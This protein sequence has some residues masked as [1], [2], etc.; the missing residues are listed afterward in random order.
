MKQTQKT[1]LR[2]WV[3]LLTV[4]GLISLAV[5]PI[6]LSAQ[7]VNGYYST[8]AWTATTIAGQSTFT[9][10]PDAAIQV[11]NYP[12]NAVPC[13]NLATLYLG[14][15]LASG[16]GP[17]PL[18]AD[19][20]GNFGFWA[21]VGTYQYTLTTTSGQS[22]GP[23]PV[24]LGGGS[25][26]GGGGSPGGSSGAIQYNL[27]GTSFGGVNISGVIKGN[28]TLAPSA[29]IP[30]VDFL[31]PNGSGAGLSGV[32]LL[33]Q[34]NSFSQTQTAPNFTA[35]QSMLT[36]ALTDSGL[37]S[38]NCVQAGSGGLLTTS[39][40]PCGS[41]GGGGIPYPSAGVPQSTGSAWGSSL[42]LGTAANNIVQVNS[43]G[44]LPALNSPLLF[45]LTAANLSG[46]APITIAG[47][48]TLSF[49]ASPTFS[50]IVR[51]SYIGLT[52]NITSFTLAAAADGQEKTLTF[53]QLSSG[54]FT[55]TPPSNVLGFLAVGPTA[56]TCS[57]Q[58]YSYSATQTAW[59]ADSL[60]ITSASN[61]TPPI[62]TV[63]AGT[64][65][66]TSPTV[67]VSAGSNND[68]GYI[69]LTTGST[70]SPSAAIATVSF[71][72]PFP[73]SPRCYSWPATA[74]TQALVG[75]AA[76]QVF[77]AN[78]STS[79]FQITQ[80]STGLTASTAYEWGYKCSVLGIPLYAGANNF[81]LGSGIP[82]VVGG[83]AWGT[84]IAAPSGTVVG[85]TDTQTLT[86]KTLASPTITGTVAIPTGSTAVTQTTGDN[87][88]KLATDAFVL[89]NGG[90]GSAVFPSTPGVVYNTTTS[91]ARNATPSDFLTL[92]GYYT[93]AYSSGTTYK[94]NDVAV[95]GSGNNYV[96]LSA[97]NVGNALTNTTFWHFLGGVSST[98][99]G[100]NCVTAG[101]VQIGISTAGVPNCAAVSYLNG[102]AI[103]VSQG[104]IGINSSGQLITPSLAS[105]TL[106]GYLTDE[107]GT[108]TVVFNISPGLAGTP[109]APT[110]T[111]GTNTTQLA[112]TAFVLAN[113]GGTFTGAIQGS[114]PSPTIT[115]FPLGFYPQYTAFGDSIT[116]GFD[117]SS[118]TAAYPYVL[119]QAIGA[120]PVDYGN[121]GG[122]SHQQD[123]NIFNN[124]I[125]WAPQTVVS[126]TIG[127]NNVAQGGANTNQESMYGLNIEAQYAWFALTPA[128]K[129]L[130]N[131]GSVTY[132]GTWAHSTLFG[133]N[134]PGKNCT[135][136]TSC[137]ATF[138]GTGSILY[139]ITGAQN[140]NA[141]TATL[142]CDGT[143]TGATL[144]FAGQGGQTFVG[145]PESTQFT[146]VALSAGAH[147]CIVQST[148]STGVLD[149]E[150]A[151]FLPGTNITDG[152]LVLA[153]EIPDLNPVGTTT[154]AYQAFN[155]S[156]TTQLIGDG[157]VN[158]GYVVTHGVL[159]ANNYSD[160]V[161]HPNEYGQWLLS[162]PFVSELATISSKT[163]T[164]PI[165]FATRVDNIARSGSGNI[166][167]ME[168]EGNGSAIS[169]GSL[170]VTLG[171]GAG[172]DLTTSTEVTAIGQSACG[173]D[174][175]GS[176]NT[177]IGGTAL[178][179]VTTG[180]LNTGIGAAALDDLIGGSDNTAVGASALNGQTAGNYNSAVGYV[181]CEFQTTGGTD[182]CMGAWTGTTLATGGVNVTTD[183][184][185][186]LLGYGASKNTASIIT[187]STAIGANA[188]ASASHQVSLG[189]TTVTSE[190]FGGVTVYPEVR[191][192]LTMTAGTSD[193]AT[194]TG[195]TASSNCLFSPTNA[196]AAT[197]I[198]TTYISS[199]TTN[200]VTIT[201]VTGASTGTLNI[202]CTIN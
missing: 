176:Y 155:A 99:T 196:T 184:T 107:T 182:T 39:G 77:P 119:G 95:D 120:Y 164:Q 68:T 139:L 112:T 169:T 84:T 72:N 86:N 16:T 134:S 121:V 170:N 143:A 45:N 67:S 151:A 58:H 57:S 62:P 200:S 49:T 59:I 89:A 3:A 15:S 33:A 189:S 78:T 20:Y 79:S 175:T 93:G 97:G 159:G 80:G 34:A 188:L 1:K 128:R 198:A 172:I 35:S 133:A 181:A 10:I 37:T 113:S 202:H 118:V 106:A 124:P 25:G 148:S 122:T 52:G 53:C 82:I 56:G 54:N 183:T 23:Y 88:T 4:I 70:P 199:V 166:Q 8:F 201:H 14:P 136:S 30:G 115:N 31:L 132:G 96:S 103:P 51:Q 160:G 162:V 150:W 178:N 125:T 161:T 158:L 152:P 147:S 192:T 42:A 12:A 116:Y 105:A 18:T 44:Q 187:D 32:A 140:T 123:N 173:V 111:T 144:N 73:A 171:N 2:M 135:N 63:A 41:G 131:T 101:Q 142:T 50:T 46:T 11:C 38:G 163:I 110:A 55:V 26:G 157:L 9:P 43:S 145:Q 76:A 179:A 117:L 29:A 87:S 60:G 81:P 48:E 141:Q 165:Y 193:A 69:L 137:S 156:T 40:T 85:T 47:S 177:C 168:T 174:T 138:T 71:G 154:A 98:I 180:A 114:S 90:G 22:V 74:A 75:A 126:Y 185:L 194:V 149:L 191:G 102:L 109:T 104:L 13:T 130:F 146:R 6:A 19:Q 108:G 36:P 197:N 100:G 28:G 66:G 167:M 127:T 190:L 153:G 65:A 17:N 61:T 64:G 92:T 24:V 7:N 27:A 21:A 5:S 186:T 129:I 195:A 83:G 94:F 91:A